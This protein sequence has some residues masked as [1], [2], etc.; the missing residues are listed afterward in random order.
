MRKDEEK[1]MAS[2]KKT[3]ERRQSVMCIEGETRKKLLEVAISDKLRLL[4]SYLMCIIKRKIIGVIKRKK[5]C[6][7]VDQSDEK[8]S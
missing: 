7:I 8:T 4:V 2:E 3:V 1:K 6:F 5:P